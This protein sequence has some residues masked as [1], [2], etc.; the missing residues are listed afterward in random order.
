M[1]DLEKCSLNNVCNDTIIQLI[2]QTLKLP[3]GSFF[4]ILAA[5]VDRNGMSTT[6]S[7][8]KDIDLARTFVLEV[9]ERKT[10]NICSTIFSFLLH[11]IRP[12]TERSLFT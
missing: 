5:S 7:C 10:Q 12:G 8:R 2:C 6:A 3:Q 1:S 4:L 11:E 9:C